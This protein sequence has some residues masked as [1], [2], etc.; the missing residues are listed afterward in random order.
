MAMSN[1][2]LVILQSFASAWLS[3]GLLVLIAVIRLVPSGW[4]ERSLTK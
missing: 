4:T 1:G 2:S 3:D